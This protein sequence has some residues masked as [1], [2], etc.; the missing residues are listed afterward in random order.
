[1]LW[2]RF[3]AAALI[4]STLVACS[5][6][7]GV[8]FPA[9]LDECP[10]ADYSTCDTR[11]AA[12]QTRLVELAA[13]I[14]GVNTPAQVPVRVLT[15]QELLDDLESEP[16]DTD[17]A[18][19][20]YLERAL[21]DLKL[22]KR[23][24]LT[25]S[26][27]QAADMVKRVSGVYQDV[28]RGIVLVDRGDA[29]DNAKADALLV[30]EL[31]HALQ[32]RKYD[33]TGWREQYPS[34]PDTELALRSVTDGQ[35]TLV[36]YR[37]WA[38]MSGTDANGV[39]WTSTFLKLRNELFAS[40]RADEL[41]YFASGETFPYGFGAT[42]ANLAWETDGTSY[43]DAQ[44]KAPPQTTLEV[45][46]GNAQRA[47]PTFHAPPFQTPVITDDYSA[48]KDT[49][50]GAFLLELSAH[51][52]GDDSADPL[53]L[54]LAWRGDRLWTFAGPDGETGWIWQLQVADEATAQAL[55]TLADARGLTSESTRERL[56]LLGGDE[57]PAFL[58]E[59]GRAFLDAER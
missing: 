15:E 35:A 25:D 5:S 12:C 54:Q 33:L 8:V 6:G 46:A 36:Q 21:V 41:P 48:V 52:L 16:S 20:P 24:A 42:L 55:Q 40:A 28:E 18:A 4:G 45:L 26:A 1:M 2:S 44:F 10:D 27:G 58:L 11:E 30:R 38:A 29:L 53:P 49:V 32:D 37:A 3:A 43:R 39:D 13:C 51:R 19:L 7:E 14:Y 56:F 57:P 59:A 47:T 50:L 22:L 34:N 23:G 17:A 31:V 9:P